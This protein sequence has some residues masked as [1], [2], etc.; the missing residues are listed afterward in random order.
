MKLS[1]SKIIIN[2]FVRL[3]YI[4]SVTL[5]I[6]STIFTLYYEIQTVI[7]CAIGEEFYILS[8]LPNV[9]SNPLSYIFY[10][11]IAI[12]NGFLY[13]FSHYFFIPILIVLSYYLIKNSKFQIA[14]YLAIANF[15]LQVF[16]DIRAEIINSYVGNLIFDYIYINGSH[17]EIYLIRLPSFLLV[18]FMC[19]VY[20]EV[21]GSK[22]W[23]NN[24]G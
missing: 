8:L 6:I 16:Y 13:S 1:D 3:S 9:L 19:L 24:E 22:E 7:G 17:L 12:F 21:E 2:K 14:A 15:V 4:Y 10:Y 11:S 20:F 18:I 5:L 23:L